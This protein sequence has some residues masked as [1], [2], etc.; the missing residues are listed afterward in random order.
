MSAWQAFAARHGLCA[1]AVDVARIK[2]HLAKFYAAVET[3][4]PPCDGYIQ[5]YHGEAVR[6]AFQTAMKSNMAID[7]AIA[8][9]EMPVSWPTKYRASVSY[10]LAPILYE[11]VNS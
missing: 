5:L 3:I 8:M 4:D 11:V 1:V 10:H 2:R 9:A 6:S 7:A